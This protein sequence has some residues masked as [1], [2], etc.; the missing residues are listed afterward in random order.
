MI[1]ED[2]AEL[3]GHLYWDFGSF[4]KFLCL[5]AISHSFLSQLQYIRELNFK[6][7]WLLSLK[8]VVRF[9]DLSFNRKNCNCN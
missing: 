3:K 1:K 2:V 9:V 8:Y 7:Y 5:E 6:I 4:A